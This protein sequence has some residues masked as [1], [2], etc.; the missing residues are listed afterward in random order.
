MRKASWQVHAWCVMTNHFHLAW[1]AENAPG[2]KR[3]RFNPA[4]VAEPRKAVAALEYSEP[5]A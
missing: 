3:L 1:L 4:R 2:Q 5:D